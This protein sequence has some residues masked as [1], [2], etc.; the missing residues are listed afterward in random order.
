MQCLT[1][2][3]RSLASHV[4]RQLLA[5]LMDCHSLCMVENKGDRAELETVMPT[6]CLRPVVT[7]SKSDFCEHRLH[8]FEV[9]KSVFPGFNVMLRFVGDSIT[10]RVRVRR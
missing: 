8:M 9:F 10:G 6:Y 2:G 7:V 3:E 5:Y 4:E 1:C